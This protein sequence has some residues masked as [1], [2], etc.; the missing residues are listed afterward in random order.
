MLTWIFFWGRITT[1]SNTY[2]GSLSTSLPQKVPSSTMQQDEQEATPTVSTFTGMMTSL[3]P[4]AVSNAASQA[5]TTPSIQTVQDN[6]ILYIAVALIVGA[7]LIVAVTIIAV[8]MGIFIWKRRNSKKAQNSELKHNSYLTTSF[9]K[10]E[11]E[12]VHYE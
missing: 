4:S 2:A 1:L 10:D 8:V 3:Q 12:W 6:T 7:I 11:Q 9:N 5:S